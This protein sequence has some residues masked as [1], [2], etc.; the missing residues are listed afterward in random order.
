MLMGRD[1]KIMV[2][3]VMNV[4]ARMLISKQ[5]FLDNLR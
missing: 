5:T 4:F 2:H 1:K 3:E